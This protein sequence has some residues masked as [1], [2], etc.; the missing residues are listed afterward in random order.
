M[1]NHIFFDFFGTLV[2]YSPSRRDQ[3][4][5][6]SHKI[7]KD[8]GATHSYDEFLDLWCMV[9]EE[10]DAESAKTHREY[11]MMEVGEAFLQRMFGQ[12]HAQLTPRFVNAYLVEW[13]KGVH[14]FPGLSEGD[15]A[16]PDRSRKLKPS[17]TRG[18]SDESL[19][20]RRAAGVI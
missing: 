13:N 3:G 1:L 20:S 17:S 6:I 10:F 11:S 16:F 12:P 4:Y 2:A 9:S 19:R 8:A 7:L 14:Y 5:S 15:A 18:S